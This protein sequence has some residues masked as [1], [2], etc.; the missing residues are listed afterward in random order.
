MHGCF[1]LTELG[2]WVVEGFNHIF[3]SAIRK[4]ALC[5]SFLA[6]AFLVPI[7]LLLVHFRLIAEHILAALVNDGSAITAKL[8]IASDISTLH[9]NVVRGEK[10]GS[11]YP[12]RRAQ[13]LSCYITVHDVANIVTA[14]FDRLQ[15]I[16]S[17]NISHNL[18]RV[19]LV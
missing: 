3:I 9:A 5:S 15:V 19:Q 18:C 11:S 2:Q 16:S 12:Y 10:W 14:V 1:L 13:L 7:K 4:C 8:P 6:L 17:L